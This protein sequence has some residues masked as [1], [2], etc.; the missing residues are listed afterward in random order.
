MTG[1]AGNTKQIMKTLKSI[2]EFE[3]LGGLVGD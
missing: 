2:V 1:A 3:F